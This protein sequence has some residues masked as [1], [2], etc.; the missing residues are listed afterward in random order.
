MPA[1][2]QA[3]RK[4][5]VKPR[6]TLR[7]VTS[8]DL[9]DHAHA[10]DHTLLQASRTR[11]AMDRKAVFK[12]RKKP[13]N[14]GELACSRI[15]EFAFDLGHEVD[16][17]YGW[18]AEAARFCGLPQSTMWNIISGYVTTISWKTVDHV[19]MKSGIPIGVFYELKQD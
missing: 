14:S 2:A 4:P 16:F 1:T 12:R 18:K 9:P 19:A 17:A 11:E 8:S 13:L 3:A 6:V 15:Q 10:T 5:K 7:L